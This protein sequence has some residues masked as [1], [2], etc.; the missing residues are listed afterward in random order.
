MAPQCLRPGA[1]ATF[2]VGREVPPA[3]VLLHI[4]LAGTDEGAL[5]RRAESAGIFQHGPPRLPQ[6]HEE[7]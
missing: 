5:R 3:T 7:P 1:A 6:V 2:G 4:G